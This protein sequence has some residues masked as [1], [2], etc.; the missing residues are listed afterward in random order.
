MDQSL[1]RRVCH[2]VVKPLGISCLWH[3]LC[4][5]GDVQNQCGSL[6]VLFKGLADVFAVLF[7]CFFQVTFLR[8]KFVECPDKLVESS[9]GSKKKKKKNVVNEIKIRSVEVGHTLY[10]E[11]TMRTILRHQRRESDQQMK[12]RSKPARVGHSQNIHFS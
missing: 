2:R 7:D 3:L 5:R 6:L 11:Y 10:L 9:S 8:V 12:Q 4:S 1:F